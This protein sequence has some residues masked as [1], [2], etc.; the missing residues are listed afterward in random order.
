M[1]ESNSPYPGCV[2]SEV[3]LGL[4]QIFCCLRF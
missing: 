2:W 4:L 3:M 1:V